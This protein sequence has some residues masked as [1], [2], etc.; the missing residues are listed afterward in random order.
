[1]AHPQ[2]REA[3]D[4]PDEKVPLLGP[5]TGKK[6]R[7]RC[8][9]STVGPLST[10]VVITCIT[11]AVV[12]GVTR[13]R[14]RSVADERIPDLL[15]DLPKHLRA[16]A[17]QAPRPSSELRS[18]GLEARI[19]DGK[20]APSWHTLGDPSGL[21]LGASSR[22]LFQL[23][24]ATQDGQSLTSLHCTPT[25]HEQTE[26]RIQLRMSCPSNI[27]AKFEI[28]QPAHNAEGYLRFSVELWLKRG[29]WPQGLSTLR[30]LDVSIPSSASVTLTGGPN[31]PGLPAV[32]GGRLFVGGEHP[33]A[34]T[35]SFS[36][37]AEKGSAG[38]GVF[39]D[40]RH[41]RQ[42]EKPTAVKPWHFGAV[43]GS[44]PE[45]SQARRAFVNYLHNERPGRRTPMVHYNSWFDFYGWQDEG[46]FHE[47]ADRADIMNE[48]SCIQRVESFGQHLV[49]DH[50]VKV[51]SFLIDDGWDNTKTLWE[52]DKTRFPN[53]FERVAK[54]AEEYGSGVGVW[55]SPWGGYGDSK[56]NRVREGKALGLETHLDPW[57]EEAFDLAGPKYRK[58]F[59]DAATRMRREEGV[60]LFKFDGI[61]RAPLEM[62]AML[63]MLTDVRKVDVAQHVTQKD[64]DKEWISL[65]TG[66]WPSPFFLLWADNIW[67]G[68][69]DVGPYPGKEPADGLSQ[70]QKWIRWRAEKV[71]EHIVQQS[72]FFP[73]SQLMIHG[74]VLAGHGD[75]L[76][77]G[78]GDATDVEFAQE[79]WSFV[80]L[81]LQLQELYI[82]PKRMTK[83]LWALLAEGLAWA[84][85]NAKILLDSH[86]AFGDVAK[87]TVFCTASWDVDEGR[88]FLLVQNPQSSIQNSE[89]ISLASA[90]ELPRA[91]AGKLLQLSVVKSVAG[92]E[93]PESGADISQRLPGCEQDTAAKGACRIKA[94]AQTALSLGHTEVLLIEVRLVNA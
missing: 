59:V 67:R 94:S 66:T 85:A 42:L 80:G 49:K 52:F 64:E 20:H 44:I 39:I 40:I 12:Y 7:S 87:R 32:I 36:P 1:M 6:S 51:D 76:Y 3:A 21:L 17:S 25:G 56:K 78:L 61:G 88:G 55:F 82:S 10:L 69:G 81:G 9:C 92:Q 50:G 70:R 72:S 84:R 57:N 91:Q 4:L 31:E 27:E 86:W 43:I 41:L 89:R 13:H 19:H 93:H 15:A 28:Q 63:G 77:A 83:S 65:T 38:T 29:S 60:N 34:F 23:L 90:L 73:L 58:W 5:N 71:Q 62:E 16:S 2:E 33:M 53:G 35:G 26:Q 47:K 11:A 30:L 45:E 74:V 8:I 22:P 37:A 68:D 18:G 24:P 75:A 54:K 79:V 48:T 46:F 14:E